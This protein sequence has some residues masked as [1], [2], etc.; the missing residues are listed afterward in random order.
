MLA[1]ASAGDPVERPKKPKYPK[2]THIRV[3]WTPRVMS[4]LNKDV[5]HQVWHQGGYTVIYEIIPDGVKNLLKFCIA[6]CSVDA[7]YL[8]ERG[9]EIA[10]RRFWAFRNKETWKMDSNE[11]RDYVRNA[12]FYVEVPLA[13][14]ENAVDLIATHIEGLMEK[15][16][17]Y[18]EYQLQLMRRGT[19]KNSNIKYHY[20][21]I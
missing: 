18:S 19:S 15:D 14:T 5:K 2:F 17:D 3:A 8:R 21:M 1:D 6:R 4:L 10:A 11:K 9:R 7:N 13:P 12:E 20:C 16:K